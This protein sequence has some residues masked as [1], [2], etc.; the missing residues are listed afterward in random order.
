MWFGG[1]LSW[2]VVDNLCLRYCIEVL[3]VINEGNNEL[4]EVAHLDVD[5]PQEGFDIP[6]SHDNYSLW[7]HFG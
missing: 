7:I 6:S 5:I 1:V 4:S 2:R 3:F